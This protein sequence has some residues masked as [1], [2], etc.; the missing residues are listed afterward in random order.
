MSF[1]EVSFNFVGSI[2]W[3]I[4]CETVPAPTT[5]I[6]AVSVTCA[7][8][9]TVASEAVSV[10]S[11]AEA[12]AA[13]SGNDANTTTTDEADA[14]TTRNDETRHEYPHRTCGN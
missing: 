1:T 10:R 13:T 2:V 8:G 3:M 6:A 11:V 4:S 14:T 7:A 12:R 9:S 5:G